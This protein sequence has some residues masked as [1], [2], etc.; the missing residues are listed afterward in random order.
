M[1][2]LN[3]IKTEL[4]ILLIITLYIFFSIDLDIGILNHL[5]NL[6]EKQDIKYLFQFF[7][8]VLYN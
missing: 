8:I 3:N 1:G 7:S 2:V 5:N 6:R 4:V